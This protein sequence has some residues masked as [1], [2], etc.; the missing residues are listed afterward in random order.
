[1]HFGFNEEQKMLKEAI[2][3]FAEKEIAPLLDEAEEKREYPVQI[4]PKMGEL[5]YLCLCYPAQ[6][7]GGGMGLVGECIATEELNRVGGGIADG[8]R[9]QA[10]LGTRAIFDHGT[11][12]Q[13]QKYLVPAIKG[14]KIVAFGLTEP[15]AGSD[16]AAVETTAVKKGDKYIING[17]KMYIT[18]GTICDFVVIAAYTDKSLGIRGGMSMLIVDKDTPGFTRR[19]LAKFCFHSSDT[20]ELTFEDCAVPVE[21]LIGEEGRGFYYFMETLDAARITHSAASLGMAQAAY[22][23]CLSYVQQRV[24]FGQ[25]IFKFQVNSFKL[26]KMATEIE[27]AR[28]LMYRAAWLHDQGARRFNEAAM[29]KMVA[30]EV[31]AKVANEAM[32]IHGGV[33]FM[34]ES[35]VHRFYRDARLKTITEGTNEIMQLVIARGIGLR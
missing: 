8:P 6:Y 28:W 2:R 20:A 16:V 33:A 9:V 24:Q 27:A 10:G 18:N 17:T 26:A 21:K 15:N 30:S 29:T 12:E 13:K 35:P 7:G 34:D 22:E 25:P 14:Q 32:Q 3:G 1:M 23:A 5:G 4:I 19:R 11:E 31:A